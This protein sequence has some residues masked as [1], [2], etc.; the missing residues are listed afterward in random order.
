[1]T[2]S[3]KGKTNTGEK[4]GEWNREITKSASN[5]HHLQKHHGSTCQNMC[6]AATLGHYSDNVVDAFIQSK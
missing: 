4:R 5:S 1:M 2:L 6:T 3:I